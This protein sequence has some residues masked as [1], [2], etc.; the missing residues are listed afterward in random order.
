MFSNK[1]NID[2]L[3][4]LLLSVNKMALALMTKMGSNIVKY[5]WSTEILPILIDLL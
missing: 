1:K 2:I 3:V 4:F 5:F